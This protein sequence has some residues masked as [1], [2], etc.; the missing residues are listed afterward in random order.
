MKKIISYVMVL[1]VSITSLSACHQEKKIP[2]L[3]VGA[4]SSLAEIE[5]RIYAAFVDSILQNDLSSLETIDKELQGIT[6]RNQANL[7]WYWRSYLN[8]YKAIYYVRQDDK[9][10]AEKSCDEAITW[11]EDLDNKTS[12]DY[13]LLALIQSFGI[14]FKGAKAMFIS[15]KI[16]K[17]AKKA[18][19]MEPKNLRAHFV[20]ASN[21]FYTPEK[22]GG[23]KNAEKFLLKAIALPNQKI[24]NP[25]L[26][27]W[28]KERA[29]EM[30]IKLYIKKKELENA[31]KYF[32]EG[33]ELYPES[34]N[35]KQLA[36]KLI[37]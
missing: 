9:K 15:S 4:Q 31:K 6:Q 17:N 8:Y 36:A 14:Q 27:S 28:G 37:E 29:Y 26:P 23:G 18:I 35:L 19:A 3:S 10:L 32:K 1:C 34:Y 33:I 24:K 12:E 13:A 7:V 20:F 16:K 30:L 11:L 22:Y 5:K 2:A 25:Y 21:D